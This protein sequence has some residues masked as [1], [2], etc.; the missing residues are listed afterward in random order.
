MSDDVLLMIPGP[1]NLPPQVREALSRPAIYHRGP[2]FAQLIQQCSTDLQPLFGTEEDVLILTASSTG[3]MEASIVNFLSP[4]DKVI[5]IETGKFGERFGEI[6]QAFGAQVQ[7]LN[8]AYGEAAQPQRLDELVSKVQPQAVLLVQNE[9]STGV[10]QDVAALARVA[11][12]HDAL[13]IVDAVSGLGAIPFRMDEWG[14]DVVA[15]GSQKALMLPPGLGF[16]AVS[17]RAWQ[18]AAKAAMPR[19]YFDLSAARQMLEQGQTPFTP[20]TALIVALREALQLIHAEGP[21]TVYQRH[22]NLAGMARAGME[23]LGLEL[24]ADHQ[25]ASPVVTA[26]KM[27]QGLDS[28]WL[29]QAVADEH[30]ILISGGQGELKGRIFRIAHVGWVGPQQIEQTLT[31]VAE[32]L[33]QLGYPCATEAALAAARA[34]ANRG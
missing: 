2:A 20:N 25:Y 17:P 24:L 19:Y 21:E 6:A 3:A 4:G 26:V 9:T 1:T 31:A 23:A 14:V 30:N 33:N 22:A 12:E 32:A 29:V 28:A 7:W 27:P 34:A 11:R 5:A 8:V 10:C 15:S 18:A 13:A 16:A